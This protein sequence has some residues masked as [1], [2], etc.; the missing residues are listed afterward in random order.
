VVG[1]QIGVLPATTT[2]AVVIEEWS[3]D[4]RMLGEAHEQGRDLCVWT[5]SDVDD[6]SVYLVRGVDGGITDEVGRAAA[7]R[8]RLASGR[9]MFYLERVRGLVAIG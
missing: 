3:V 8:K 5:L 1:L 4:D 7:A 9:M 2:G 6:V